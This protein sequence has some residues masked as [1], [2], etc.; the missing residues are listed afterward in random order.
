MEIT[1][2]GMIETSGL[3]SAIE[4]ADAGLKAANVHLLGTDYVRGGLVMVR[5]EGDVAAVQAAVDAGT[6]AA[7]R[8]GLVVSSHVIP[9]AMPEVFCML[10][11]DPSV[12]PGKRHQGGCAS[13]GGCEGG[14]RELR[15]IQQAEKPQKAEAEKPAEKAPARPGLEEMKGWKKYKG[16]VWTVRVDNSIFG[17]YHPFLPVRK[18]NLFCQNLLR[19]TADWCKRL[20][21][22]SF[23]GIHDCCV[24]LDK[25]P[26]NRIQFL[27]LLF[28]DVM[29]IA[30]SERKR[31]SI[32][33][34]IVG[35][36]GQ[37]R[38]LGK[39][40][41]PVS[42]FVCH[43]ILHT[44]QTF[45][46][47]PSVHVLKM[48]D[49]VQTD[50]SLVQHGVN[51]CCIQNTVIHGYAAVSVIDPC[52]LTA[53]LHSGGIHPVESFLVQLFDRAADPS[54]IAAI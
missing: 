35:I 33:I 38:L 32:F 12:G 45:G 2:L 29:I 49:R 10:A 5:F 50:V 54:D 18:W 44:G 36:G 40:I 34:D 16:N 48:R 4:A 24:Q 11:S 30:V 25:F 19:S 42:R 9:R 17:S 51:Q 43:I 8:V 52:V 21:N 23:G 3:L 27:I 13:C 37:Y 39:T 31:I 26:R 1:A 20:R 7:Q 46:Q 53:G 47:E 6:M 22:G 15:C 14:M 41:R 28:Q